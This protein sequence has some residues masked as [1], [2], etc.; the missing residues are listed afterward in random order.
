MTMK[1][2]VLWIFSLILYILAACTI[3]SHMI[4]REM[5]N[6]VDVWT[7]KSNNYYGA[8]LQTATTYLFDNSHLFEIQEGSGWESGMR[9][10]E[11]L[12]PAWQIGFVESTPVVELSSSRAY[13]FVRSASRTPYTGELVEVVDTTFA[14]STYL[15]IYPEGVP[16]FR[17]YPDET[18]VVA[19]SANAIMLTDRRG[20][21]P[22]M[23]HR[24]KGELRTIAAPGWRIFDTAAVEQFLNQLPALSAATVLLIA[25][26]V[27]WLL[28][29]IWSVGGNSGL[30]WFNSIAAA[31]LLVGVWHLLQGV[32][33]PASLLP[34]RNILNWN[35][36]ADTFD[37]IF[38]HLELLGSSGHALTAMKN[39]IFAG[40]KKT[41]WI[42][43]GLFGAIALVEMM[44]RLHGVRLKKK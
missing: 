43:S 11:I 32:D 38:R 16:E 35:H 31:L 2:T 39:Q 12:P 24:M 21:V 40:V 13:T 5:T 1:K 33:L 41:I 20:V 36:Y 10:L 44:I 15:L 30:I 4:E 18:T 7:V 17:M 42:G 37:M 29:C 6:Q 28:S 27:L 23:E 14:P 8:P 3:L 34:G 22:F 26:L 25:G 19:Q 9:S